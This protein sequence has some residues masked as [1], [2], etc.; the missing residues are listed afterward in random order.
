MTIFLKK[1]LGSLKKG[2]F[3]HMD[4]NDH[5]EL[6][7][8]QVRNMKKLSFYESP[9]LPLQNKILK[10]YLANSN[11]GVKFLQ[12]TVNTR[13]SGHCAQMW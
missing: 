8:S 1:V 4:K 12:D 6:W 5:I 2:H 11:F 10:L 7:I 9:E 13:A 3:G